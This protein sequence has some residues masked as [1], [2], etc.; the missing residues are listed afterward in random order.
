[1]TKR[2]AAFDLTL[3]VRDRGIA[4]Y[5][6]LYESLRTEI[7][8]GHLHPGTRLPA[9]RDLA[10]QYGLARGTIIAAFEQLKSEGYL[11]GTMGSGT[12][13]SRVLPE[14]LLQVQRGSSVNATPRLKRQPRLSDY[15]RRARLFGNY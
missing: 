11:E 10:S 6:W 13:V 15:G 8:R 7:L 3:P 2:S 5:R 4:A 1:M 14:E 12:F 9:T